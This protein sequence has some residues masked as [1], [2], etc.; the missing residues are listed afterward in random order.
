MLRQ[1]T[2]ILTT[3][4]L[5]I[6]T[7]GIAISSHYCSGKL[8]ETT[9]ITEAD[10]CCDMTSPCCTND[11]KVIRLKDN[12]VFEAQQVAPIATELHLLFST[13]IVMYVA[14]LEHETPLSTN[15][16]ESPPP[17]RTS[18]FLSKKQSFLC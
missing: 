17:L 7:V 11:T 9:I 18:E 3:I 6:A 15:I 5:L 13:I 2:H 12:F 8:V 14:P 1:F 10:G 4:L 16:N